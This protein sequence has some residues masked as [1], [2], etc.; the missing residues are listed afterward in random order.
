ME[1]YLIFIGKM[2]FHFALSY[3]AISDRRLIAVAG[4]IQE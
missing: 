2:L 4:N 1:Q 3:A